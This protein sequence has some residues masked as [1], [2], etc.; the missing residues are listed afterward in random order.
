MFR[1]IAAPETIARGAKMPNYF[2][3]QSMTFTCSCGWKGLGSELKLGEAFS[4]LAEYDCPECGSKVVTISYPTSKEVRE[5]A[6]ARNAEAIA[7]LARIEEGEQRWQRVQESRAS[8]L[9]EPAALRQA[10]VRAVLELEKIDTDHWLVLY[11]NGLELHREL[12]AYE[13]TEPASRLLA[14]LRRQYGARLRSFDYGPAI[15]YLAGDD[16]RALDVLGNLVADLP[17]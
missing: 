6:A 17:E 4:E 13:D 10:E 16:L 1:A 8:G 14:L 12:A 15:N 9:N 3:Y 5:A 2:D 11:A 7:E